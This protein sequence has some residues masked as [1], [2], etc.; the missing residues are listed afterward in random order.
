VRQ[1]QA[2]VKV[3]LLL[4][5]LLASC[6]TP[7]TPTEV[8]PSKL[9][10]PLPVSTGVSVGS[11][12][13]PPSTP[14][15]TKA[16]V[17]SAA[18]PS[19]T[20]TVEP[21]A[22]LRVPQFTVGEPQV[23][24]KQAER[25]AHDLRFWPD[26]NMGFMVAEDGQYTFFAANSIRTARTVGTLDDPATMVT[27]TALNIQ[28][29]SSDYAYSAGGPVYYHPET[30]TLLMFYHAERQIGRGG[31]PFYSEIG[32]AV[33][34][35]D[36]QTFRNLGIILTPR[37]APSTDLKNSV[38]VAGGTYA[39]D[40]G[41][42]YVYFRDVLDTSLHNN[43]SVARALVDDVLNAALNG[44]TT[45][46]RKYY[47]GEFSEPGLG[48][49]SSPLELGNPP[50]R[51][52]SVTYNATLDHFL[53]VIAETLPGNRTLLHLTA[54][55]DG[56][57]W[58]PRVPLLDRSG[59]LFYPSII[60]MEG[61]P[62][63]TDETFYVFYTA[64]ENGFDRWLDASLERIQVTLA[65]SMVELPHQWEFD[66]NGD[67]EGWMPYNQIDLF[68]VVDGHLIVEPS[69]ADPYMHSS[70]LGL[71][72]ERYTRIEVRMRS[73]MSGWGQFF[74]T[75]TVAPDIDE[76]NSKRFAVMADG[77]FH[78]Y[79]L[80]MATVPGWQKHL[81]MLRFDPID[82]ITRVE[83]DYIRLVP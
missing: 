21:L 42:F 63:R 6:S 11:T 73:G 10:A 62:H 1:S 74:F 53:M 52:M 15:P 20:L 60:G 65:G 38:E 13:A 69:G 47:Q 14:V 72:T 68:Q 25:D 75:S 35:D 44:T 18:P 64:S 24:Y 23:I 43:L 19:P 76:V 2:I 26:G 41:Y 36:G 56:I 79:T 50:N 34:K 57:T 4:S 83:I 31:L 22:S 8:L 55:E 5:L 40:N 9:T 33:S 37:L 16:K 67:A 61:N 66:T 81:G 3:C 7:A 28:G 49:N 27:N 82:Q 29:V 17:A 12:D 30:G 59:E 51:W 48:G 39:V 78:T 58:S 80:D 32:M 45:D 46:W 71:S 77:V 54:S 70:M